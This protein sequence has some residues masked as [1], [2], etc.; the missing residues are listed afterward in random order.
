[1]GQPVSG[2]ATRAGFGTIRGSHSPAENDSSRAA[3]GVKQLRGRAATLES[4]PEGLKLRLTQ[5]AVVVMQPL[6][7][8]ASTTHCVWVWLG[9]P[10]QSGG[11][12]G[13]FWNV[14]K[15][16]LGILLAHTLVK[17]GRKDGRRGS[18]ASVG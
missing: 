5:V 4:K 7:P 10:G 13:Q 12:K 11:S 8:Q 14:P 3:R 1:M 6:W 2:V 15:G 18:G 9:F 16:R 17:E